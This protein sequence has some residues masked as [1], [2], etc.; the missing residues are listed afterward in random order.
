MMNSANNQII[1]FFK[2]NPYSSVRVGDKT[3]PCKT[4]TPS[5]SGPFKNG[6]RSEVIDGKWL[7]ILI[8]TSVKSI[9]D[10]EERFLFKIDGDTYKIIK[11]RGW[12][13]PNH[14]EGFD[15]LKLSR[16]QVGPAS[17]EYMDMLKALHKTNA[18]WTC[19]ENIYDHK[20]YRDALDETEL[21]CDRCHR[22]EYPEEYDCDDDCETEEDDVFT[23][24][25]CGEENIDN[26]DGVDCPRC[27]EPVCD[28][29]MIADENDGNCKTDRCKKCNDDCEEEYD[30]NCETCER[31][32]KTDVPFKAG[33]DDI[34]RKCLKCFQED[35]DLKKFIKDALAAND[36]RDLAII[37]RLTL[38][39]E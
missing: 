32:F 7:K 21:T 18:C 25:C 15:L 9:I 29:C 8:Y 10:I 6:W 23:C 4:R 14:P 17:M 38:N 37:N 3:F 33:D 28:E 30:F 5:E 24:K 1:H 19:G 39:D 34:P 27:D 2:T 12:S 26:I 16:S 11:H 31:P 22:E 13:F 20:V 36:A 35:A